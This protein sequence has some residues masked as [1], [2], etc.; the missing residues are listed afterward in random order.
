M[1]TNDYVL[2]GAVSAYSFLFFDQNAGIN[3]LFFSV[4]LIILLLIRNKTLLYSMKWNWAAGMALL[5]ATCILFHSS[6]IAIIA[7]VCSLIL[8]AGFSF[9]LKTSA[10]FTFMFG[11][12]SHLSSVIFMIIDTVTRSTAKEEAPAA[13]KSH[14][15]LAIVFVTVVAILFFALYKNS[16]PIF[17][18][19]TKWINL[20]FLTLDWAWFTFVGLLLLYPFVYHRVVPPIESWEN[21][22]RTRIESTSSPDNQKRL[23]TEKLSLLCLFALLNLMLVLINIG[24]VNTILLN[25]SLPAGVKHSDFVHNGVGTLIFSIVLAVGI[26]MYFLRGDLNFIKGNKMFKFLVLL[27]IFQNILMLI[28]TAYRNQ[29]YISEYTLTYKRIGVYVW[30]LLSMLGLIITAMKVYFNQTNW[31][32]IRYNVAIWFTV[33]SLGGLVDWDLQITRYNLKNKAFHEIDFN[34]LM[35]LS[36]TN[37]PE[38]L[39]FC[40]QKAV[41]EKIPFT[42]EEVRSAGHYHTNHYYISLMHYKLENYLGSYRKDWRSWD[43]RDERIM[44]YL[45]LNQ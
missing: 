16:N 42:K 29:L 18:E 45:G 34:Y 17:A 37:I 14:K 15:W 5:S 23:E 27:W 41:M 19:Y 38:M 2:P 39:E 8:L 1:K 10:L 24:D 4:A 20:D 26:V 44:N 12:Y 31:F 30:L 33:L 32:L 43:L 6:A 36:N 25:G 11:M 28:S 21:G 9:N 40:K 7:N 13:S 22:L 35:E 3:F